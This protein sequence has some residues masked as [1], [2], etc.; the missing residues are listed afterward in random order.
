MPRSKKI[1]YAA[2][3]TL[4][5]DGRYMGWYYPPGSDKRK[6][7][8]SRDPEKLY[9]KIQELE[10]A[11][12]K[13]LTFGEAAESWHD[14]AWDGLEDG[15]K[16]CYA[17]HYKRAMERF[18]G[19]PIAS[20]TSADVQ[21][22]LEWL[23]LQGYAKSTIQKQKIMY[24]MIFRHAI[25]CPELPRDITTNPVDNVRVP[26]GAKPSVK[27]N[28][29][30]DEI[31]RQIRARATTA[32]WGTFALFLMA[33]GLRRGEALA[34]QWGDVDF[35]RKTIDIRKS[36]SYY[37]GA[38]KI[39]SPKTEAG[40][41]EIPLLPPLEAVL[42]RPKGAKDTDYIFCG[43][44]QSKPMPISTYRR[45]W[46]HYCKDMGFVSTA[47]EQRISKDKRRY[48]VTHYHPSITA[49]VLRHGYAT[50]LFE[51]GVD[52][53]TAQH[54]LGHSDV[55]TTIAIY[56]HLRDEKKKNSLDKLQEYIKTAM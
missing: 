44:S 29:P 20:I 36:A 56:T 16:A 31:V 6:P 50:L 53:Y 19:E 7:A 9:H 39:K 8:Y 28:A 5:A 41:R 46:L 3:Y 33:T 18:G 22:H 23:K 30:E 51:A 49:H 54:L 24:K 48:T 34:I 47:T 26:K 15:T 52:V 14:A 25:V 43:E 10:N 55:E 40:V 11:E 32:Y 45:R 38:P 42:H 27:R 37:S 35:N 1:D 4:R 21:N 17:A 13:P 12:P 2:M